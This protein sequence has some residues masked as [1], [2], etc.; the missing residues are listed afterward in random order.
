VPPVVDVNSSH[1]GDD[2]NASAISP[3]VAEGQAP[4][5]PFFTELTFAESEKRSAKSLA[6]KSELESEVESELELQLVRVMSDA[7]SIAR[8][9]LFFF[10]ERFS[11]FNR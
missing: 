4:T 1:D 6:L 5:V 8:T 3:K 2:I 7:T 11:T 9:A 10:M